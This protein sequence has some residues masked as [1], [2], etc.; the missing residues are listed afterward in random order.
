MGCSG[1]KLCDFYFG[2]ILVRS[3]FDSGVLILGCFDV[4]DFG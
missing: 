4:V 3:E 2:F 1:V